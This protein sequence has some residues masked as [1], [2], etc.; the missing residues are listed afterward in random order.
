[1]NGKDSAIP[2]ESKTKQNKTTTTKPFNLKKIVTGI[3]SAST[4]THPTWL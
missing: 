2:G 1:M 3:Y 4:K